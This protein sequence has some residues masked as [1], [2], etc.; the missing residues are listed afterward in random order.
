MSGLHIIPSSYFVPAPD[1]PIRRG[2]LRNQFAY[3]PAPKSQMELAD[4]ISAL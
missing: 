2:S 1:G 3:L 4:R